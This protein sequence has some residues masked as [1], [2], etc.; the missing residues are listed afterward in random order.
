V[1]RCPP[2]RDRERLDL[3]RLGDEVVGP[4]A[5]RADRGLEAAERGQ[6]QHGDVGAVGDHALAQLEAGHPLHVEIGDDHVDVV[7][8]DR[9]HRIGAV[10]ERDDLEPAL[11][12]AERD[13]VDHLA[14]VIDHEHAGHAAPRSAPRSAARSLTSALRSPVVRPT[15]RVIGR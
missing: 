5:D 2:D 14:L 11:L 12:E 4:G 1:L 15:R 10:A 7:V 6:H 8:G 3:D 13:Q 9:R